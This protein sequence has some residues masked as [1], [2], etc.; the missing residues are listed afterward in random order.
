MTSRTFSGGRGL[1][2]RLSGNQQV[3]FDDVGDND[4][5]DLVVS[6]NKGTFTD[7]GKLYNAPQTET[8][9]APYDPSDP[10]N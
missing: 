10:N 7:G 3:Q 2:S 5:N 1:N 6:V 8:G 4:Y 9:T